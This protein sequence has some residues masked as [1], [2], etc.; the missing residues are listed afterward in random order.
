MDEPIN[1]VKNE[2]IIAMIIADVLTE[3]VLSMLRQHRGE[4]RGV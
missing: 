3:C 4:S 1:G 2:L